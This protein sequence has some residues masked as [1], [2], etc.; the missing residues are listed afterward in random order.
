MFLNRLGSSGRFSFSVIYSCLQKSLRRGDVDRAI[1]MAYEFRPNYLNA[2]KGRLIQ[3]CTEDCPNLML[4]ADIYSNPPEM[5]KLLQFIVII[6]AHVKCRD[7]MYG[8]RLICDDEWCFDVPEVEKGKLCVNGERA[9]MLHLLRIA[10]THIC[11]HRELEFIHYFQPL[12]PKLKLD[13]IYKS[14]GKHITFLTM[15]CVYVCIEA[16]HGRYTLPEVAV[17]EEYKFLDG[18]LPNYVYDKHVKSSPPEQKT[19]KFFIENCIIE[20]RLPETEI[21]RRGKELYI[22]TNKGVGDSMRPVVKDITKFENV[23]LIQTQLITARYKP[24]V[25]YCSNDGGKTYKYVIKGPF[26]DM[27][28]IKILL[29]SDKLKNDLLKPKVKYVSFPVEIGGKMYFC[30][31]NLIPIKPTRD[32]IETQSSKIENNVQIYTGEK[33]LFT[34]ETLSELSEDEELRLLQVLL[35][36]KVIGTNDTCCRNL[37]YYDEEIYSIDDPVLL[38][39]TKLMFKT[40]VAQK[41]VKTYQTMCNKHFDEIMSTLTEWYDIIKG[42]SYIS[43]AGRKFMISMCN[44]FVNEEEWEFC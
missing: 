41:Y 20:P 1:D 22:R 3:N 37:I 12:F 14:S 2:L 40:K 17:E 8:L 23:K 43:E 24:R 42:L 6:C 30:Q 19:Y 9:D 33:Y 35:F 38:T 25:S 7:G 5:E 31:N 11:S 26:K 29:L 16:V 4:I 36:R 21:E 18:P 27:Q 15:L 13:A 44:K 32:N 34:N 10:W 39:E 28:D